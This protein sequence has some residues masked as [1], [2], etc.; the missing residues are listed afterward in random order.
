MREI[1][2]LCNRYDVG[3]IALPPKNL[4]YYYSLANKFF[5]FIQARVALALSPLPEMTTLCH[6]YGLGVVA[7]DFTAQGFANA[8]MTLNRERIW[9]YKQQADRAAHELC[10][11]KNYEILDKLLGM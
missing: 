11:E 3:V 9:A 4:N 1:I 8:L 10:A 5:Q 2:P 6:R 7:E